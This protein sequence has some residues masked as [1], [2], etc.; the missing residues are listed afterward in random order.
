MKALEEPIVSLNLLC[1]IVSI[2]VSYCLR[3]FFVFF[4]CFL[5]FS[6]YTVFLFFLLDMLIVLYFLACQIVLLSSKFVYVVC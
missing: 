4:L 5:T 3:F 1:L 2:F 6:V